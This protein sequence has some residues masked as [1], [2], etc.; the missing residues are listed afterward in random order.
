MTGDLRSYKYHAAAIFTVTVWG[1]TFVSTKVLI[2]N[3]LSPSEIFFLRFALAYLC[4]WPLTYLLRDRESPRKGWWQ[5]LWAERWSDELMIALAGMVGGSMYFL[6]ENAALVHAPASNVSLIV[7]TAPVWTAMLL[8]VLY[9]GERMSRR[10]IGGCLVAFAGVVL[11]VLNGHF[12]LHL[13]PAGDLLSLAAALMW[14]IY[15]LI[16]KHLAGHYPT[17]FIT[18]KIFFY[19]LL[20][21]LPAFWFDP[22][23]FDPAV[24]ARPV[25]WTNL[26]FLGVVAS[27][28]CFVLWN[29]VMHRL[30]AVRT[31]N[32]IYFNPLV[33][34]ITAAVFIDE[35]ITLTALAGAAL[36]L[37]GMWQAE[38][39]R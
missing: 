15:S 1:A 21:I 9:R 24:L 7:C 28:L 39:R 37:W 6:C 18:R 5:Q 19:G 35:R 11:V 25:V 17:L 31:T 38:R 22:P 20:T 32:Y 13:A 4:I 23:S 33:T 27:M 29:A 26:L 30:G 10:Q 34:I 14:M 12:V 16:I 2:E 36:I 3:S 8:S